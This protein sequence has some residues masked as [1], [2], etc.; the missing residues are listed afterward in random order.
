MHGT[1]VKLQFSSDLRV[2]L[3]F[4]LLSLIVCALVNPGNF[5]AIDTS[6]RLQVAR[7]IRLGEPQV[8]PDDR[9]FGVIGKNGVRQAQTGIGQSLVLVPFDALVDVLVLPQL[10]R[11]HLDSNRRAQVSELAIAFLMQSFLTS[12]VLML[13]YEVLLSFR[14]G[15]LT[16][17]AG[18]LALLFSTSC[19]PYVQCAQ[20]NELLLVLDLWALWAV[21][22][23]QDENRVRWPVVAGLACAFAILTRLNSLMET[24]VFAAYAISLGGNRKRFLAGFLPPLAAALV[25]D[26]WYHY[27]RFGAVF[28]TYIGAVGRQ[29]RPAGAPPSYPFSYPFWKGFLGTLFSPDK[30]IFL[31]DPL[32]V[33]LLLAVAL[34]WRNLAR[35]LKQALG[36]LVLLEVLYIC[37]SAKFYAFGGDVAWGHRYVIMPVQLLALFAVPIL[38]AHGKEFPAWGRRALWAVVAGA[39]VLQ[40]ASTAIAP[41]LETQQRR[42][43]YDNGVVWNRAVNLVQMARDDEDDLRFSGIPIEWRTLYYLPFQLRFRFPELARPAIAAWLALLACMPLVAFSILKMAGLRWFNKQ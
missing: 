20:E 31:F 7:W 8:S 6:R 17:A 4:V 2:R 38:I 30:S 36:W 41:N 26:R 9:Q 25:F 10:G 18:A 19:L 29:L 39:V 40:I 1:G 43:G 35:D 3:A 23:Y 15:R 24:G 16:S 12:C 13:A 28:S 11:F 32:L 27:Y 21:R 5:G 37:A 33:V 22:R 14:F 42:M 34:A